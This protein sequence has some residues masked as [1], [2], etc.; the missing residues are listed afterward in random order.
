MFGTFVS[1]L[2]WSQPPLPFP[3]NSTKY[4]IQPLGRREGEL[5]LEGEKRDSPS[6]LLAG[7]MH[8]K[9]C[10]LIKD[11]PVRMQEEIKHDQGLLRCSFSNTTHRNYS[12]TKIALK[13]TSVKP[14]YFHWSIRQNIE[15]KMIIY[16]QNVM[17]LFCIND[18]KKPLHWTCLEKHENPVLQN[19]G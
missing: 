6:E 3:V 8:L 4:P 19:L 14:R 15:N 18:K 9:T 10:W 5:V 17:L 16:L 7:E 13:I 1:S 2:I 11:H 12:E